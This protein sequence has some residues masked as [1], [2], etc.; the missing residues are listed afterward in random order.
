MNKRQQEAIREEIV[1]ER[2]GGCSLCEAGIPGGSGPSSTHHILKRS[3]LPGKAN[4]D[5]LWNKVNLA[6]ACDRHHSL[7][8]NP[9]F[10]GLWALALI[11]N[12][13]SVKANYLNYPIREEE[14]ELAKVLLGTCLGHFGRGDDLISHMNL[15]TYELIQLVYCGKVS[16]AQGSY[17][18]YCCPQSETCRKETP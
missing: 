5:L 3:E 15:T 13:N 7:M 16:H 17:C 2:G 1:K 14:W 9:P 18:V 4:E 8:G 11:R 6:V 12:G 10:R